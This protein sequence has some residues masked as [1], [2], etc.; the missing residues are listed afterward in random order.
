MSSSEL[1]PQLSQPKAGERPVHHF[2]L[3]RLFVKNG[4][5]VYARPEDI[6][7]IESADHLVRIYFQ[8]DGKV[9]K[10]VR[11]NTLKHF[12]E[13]LNNVTFLRLGRFCA[14]NTS[15]ISGGNF[16]EQCFEFDFKVSIRLAHAL[17]LN[18]FSSIGK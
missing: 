2:P 13:Q 3:F 5:Y 15:R 4:E 16:N 14:I 1:L 11:A 12:L 17:P 10:A 9:R 7:L 8:I 6:L 18:V